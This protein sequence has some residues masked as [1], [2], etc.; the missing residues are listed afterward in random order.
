MIPEAVRH[1]GLAMDDPAVVSLV[2]AW[3]EVV[4]L[5]SGGHHMAAAEPD[6]W[7]I[8]YD[9]HYAWIWVCAVK[10]RKPRKRR[11]RRRRP[12]TEAEACA[13]QVRLREGSPFPKYWHMPG[14]C[15]NYASPLEGS[16]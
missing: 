7:Y 12:P 13:I 9:P 4:S 16:G 10:S 11:C 14:F 2:D 6:A 5:G 1:I 15:R 3:G 8:D